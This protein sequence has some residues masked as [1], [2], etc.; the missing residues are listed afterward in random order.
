MVLPSKLHWENF[1][2]PRSGI[3][4]H[5]NV[6]CQRS[7]QAALAVDDFWFNDYRSTPL[8]PVF[9]IGIV[10]L[11]QWVVHC[12]GTCE[13]ERRN[14]TD[15]NQIDNFIVLVHLEV[16]HDLV[17]AISI[18]CNIRNCQNSFRKQAQSSLFIVVSC[19]NFNV[20]TTLNN[21]VDSTSSTATHGTAWSR[22]TVV[23]RTAWRGTTVS[24]RARAGAPTRAST[25]ETTQKQFLFNI[26]QTMHDGE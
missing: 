22:S 17:E 3:Q 14:H 10:T 19:T 4:V 16:T 18:F 6:K 26:N 24:A 25:Q 5:I 1:F 23:T 15:R 21:S 2:P 7:W 20:S 11:D 12:T 8:C 9:D 13:S